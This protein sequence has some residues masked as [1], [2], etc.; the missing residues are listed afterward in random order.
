MVDPTNLA[1]SLDED[2]LNKIGQTCREEYDADKDSHSAVDERRAMWKKLFSGQRDPKNY[3]WPK[4]SNT[5]VPLMTVACLQFQARAYEQ[6]IGKEIARCYCKDV[7]FIDKAERASRF[8]NYQLRY[9]MEEWEGDMDVLLLDMPI[10][11]SA[12]KKTYY[13]ANKKRVVS[14]Y[15]GSDEL[16]APYRCKDL[17]DA[18]R[19]THIIQKQLN[20]IF[21][22]QRDGSY[23]NVNESWEPITLAEF[24]PLPAT[25]A[26]SDKINYESEP[27][28]QFI[29]TRPILEQH[30]MLDL[31]YDI[32]SNTFKTKD[33]IL[34]PY[35]VTVD[36][37]D[38]K[39]LKIVP[40]WSISPWTG[41]EETEEFFTTYSFI[42][43]PDSYCG[44]GFGHLIDHINETADTIIN[45]LIDAGHLANVKGGFYAGIQGV[46]QG[47]LGF[48][49]GEFKP[50]NILSDDIRKHIFPMDFKEPSNV[51]FTLLGLLQDYVKDVTTTADWMSGALPPSDTAATTMLAIIEQGLKVFSVIQ[52][53][54]HRALKSELRKIFRINGMTLREKEYFMVTFDGD[55]SKMKDFVSGR[56]DFSNDIEVIPVS[57]PNISSRAEKL[58]KSQQVL[59]SVT[60]CPLS[61]QDPQA[62]Y[63]AYKAHYEAMEVVNIDK[64][65]PKPPDEPPPPPDLPP[66]EENSMAL[67]EVGTPALP[68]QDH[69]DHIQEHRVFLMSSWAEELTPQ[70][71][72]VLEAHIKE[73]LAF[74]YMVEQ[75]ANQIQMQQ[76]GGM[77]VGV[78]GIP[79]G[80]N[81]GVAS[82]PDYESVQ[83][84]AQD[85]ETGNFGAV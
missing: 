36:W 47:D 53:R 19:K 33:K 40:R 15:L 2:E 78:G 61:A 29:M 70:G 59:Q 31:N 8:L 49:M 46:K 28:T 4:A 68:Q 37:R 24:T 74:A 18:P 34:R 81:G 30:R 62:I 22:A 66:Q 76:E 69:V 23:I 55:R 60:T 85:F 26:Q 58:I 20:D 65:L 9:Q 80:G 3:P 71:K 43:N 5:H 10:M 6:L 14:R 50:V 13:D 84:L 12:H 67:K 75:A 11:G 44:Y 48:Q 27:S 45:Q 56:D 72:N 52:K 54:C 39:V 64:I 42:P 25:I 57:D 38:A 73:H 7:D 35:I 17:N 32:A 21:K 83:G 77:N 79:E 16:V 82:Q 63:E 51:L 1:K 41:E